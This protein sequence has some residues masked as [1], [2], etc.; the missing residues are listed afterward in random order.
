MI[1]NRE[2]SSKFKKISSLVLVSGMLI[3]NGV[4]VYAERTPEAIQKDYH[5]KQYEY[6]Q[7][8][9]NPEEGLFDEKFVDFCQNGV[10]TY[11]DEEYSIN[12]LYIIYG[13]VDDKEIVYLQS[14]K[15]PTYDL[16]TNGE[17]NS[18]YE[19]KRI[20]MLKYSDV[21]AKYYQGH[22]EEIDNNLTIDD[23]FINTMN[24][25]V[26]DYNTCLPE[27]YYYENSNEYTKKR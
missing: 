2:I 4:T 10:I 14:Y 15:K 20:M 27:T 18:S 25:F 5:S 24:S 6:I 21:F 11:N 13:Q 23:E 8:V 26:G 9:E 19:R 3:G 17:I 12:D 22:R 7:M 16:L 1:I